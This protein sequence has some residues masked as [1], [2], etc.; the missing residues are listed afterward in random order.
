[1]S[2]PGCVPDRLEPEPDRPEAV[3]LSQPAGMVLRSHSR[4]GRSEVTISAEI[5]PEKPGGAPRPEPEVARPEVEIAPVA[6]SSSGRDIAVATGSPVIDSSAETVET[7]S[8]YIHTISVPTGTG[9][10]IRIPRIHTPHGSNQPGFSIYMALSRVVSGIFNVEKFR[11]LEIG[12]RG[13][14][15]SLKVV[16]FDRLCTVSY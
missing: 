14:S 10:S 8:E 4:T 15:R 7:L 2:G 6:S 16:P 9:N 3:M 13:H 12:V 5:H 1:M 11:D